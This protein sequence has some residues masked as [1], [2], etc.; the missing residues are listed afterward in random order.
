M[1]VEIGIQMGKKWHTS[2]KKMMHIEIAQ[3]TEVK[4][5]MKMMGKTMK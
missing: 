3:T 2:S 5:R 1:E 4:N